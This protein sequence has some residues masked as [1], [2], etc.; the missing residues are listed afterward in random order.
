M[1]QTSPP[2]KPAVTPSERPRNTIAF[3]DGLSFKQAR[4]ALAVALLLSLFVAGMQITSNFLDTRRDIDAGIRAIMESN[5][6][7]ASHITLNIDTVLAAELARGML[8]YP[9]IT[10]VKL[11][12][13]FGDIIGRASDVG[14]TQAQSPLLIWLF[15]PPKAVVV[16]LYNPYTNKIDI[17]ELGQLIV[18]VDSS[19]TGQAFLH[20]AII[21]LIGV[22]LVTLLLASILMAQFYSQVTKPLTD[23]A[24]ALE[25]INPR[26]SDN[27]PI[28][29][30]RRHNRDEI[31]RLIESYNQQLQSAQD[32]LNKR[33]SAEFELKFY[34]NELENQV[35]VRTAEAMAAKQ[36]FQ[37]ILDNSPIAIACLDGNACIQQVN[38]AFIELFHYNSTEL[39]DHTTRLLYHNNEDYDAIMETAPLLLQM[40]QNY[41]VSVTMRHKNG[42]SIDI[43]LAARAV[44]PECMEDGFIFSF[45]DISERVKM[46]GAL[47]KAKEDAEAA[48]QA[49]SNFLANMSHEIRTPMNAILGMTWLALRTELDAQQRNYLSRVRTSADALLV[50]I[51]DILDFSKIEA[52]KLDIE[53]IPFE[54]EDVLQHLSSLTGIRAEEKGLEVIFET[55]PNIPRQLRGDPLRLGQILINLAFNAIKF[56]SEGEIIVA[57]KMVNE[58]QDS[59]TGR[60]MVELE[61]SVSDTGIGI[62]EQQQKQLFEAF[63][64]ADTSITRRFGGTGLGL[65]ISRRLAQLMHGRLSVESHLGQG[66]KFAFSAEFE[67]LTGDTFSNIASFELIRGM[68]ALVVDDNDSSRDIL[69]QMLACWSIDSL[70]AA[71]AEEGLALCQQQDFDLILMDWQLPGMN[72]LNACE[73]IIEQHREDDEKPPLILMITAY[74]RS[75]LSEKAK[76]IGVPGVLTKPITPSQLADT[77]AAAAHLE[78][79]IYIDTQ[80]DTRS[81]NDS[82][83]NLA[84][85][86]VLLVEDN[87]INQLL[88]RE[89]LERAQIEVHV[90]SDG[91]AGVY[92][93]QQ[94]QFDLVLMDL[95]MPIMDGFTATAKIR[96]D[97]SIKHTPIIAMTAHAMTGQRETC[98]QAGMNDYLAKPVEPRLLYSCLERWALKH[99]RQPALNSQSMPTTIEPPTAEPFDTKQRVYSDSN[100]LPSHLPGL[101]IQQGLHLAANNQDLY[102]NIASRFA[103]SYVDGIL[104]LMEALEAND[105]ATAQGWLHT[106]KGLSGNLGASALQAASKKLEDNCVNSS[107]EGLGSDIDLLE[108]CLNQVTSSLR[109]LDSTKK[110]IKTPAHAQQALSLSE[111][112]EVLESILQSLQSGDSQAASQLETLTLNVDQNSQLKLRSIKSL[113]DD[114][115]FPQALNALKELLANIEKLT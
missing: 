111:H 86:K 69:V 59:D 19:S 90:C 95:Q 63:A 72:G 26:S 83:P 37:S 71:T 81:Q 5:T 93:L 104:P 58:R 87:D 57:C 4:Q 114:F 61:I 65:T 99:N 40:G 101:N 25:S 85:L 91:R 50:I 21:T 106:I 15:G 13:S 75:E 98:L 14:H 79:S 108:N 82:I 7:A 47:L 38:P 16:D 62:S 53:D 12:D 60:Q 27:K 80:P 24:L 110:N 8:K 33:K 41:E 89:L 39:L 74:D 52:G 54:L 66:S 28:P 68:K 6:S 102:L 2:E 22:V 105:T 112:G 10:E 78:D 67:R 1:L 115:E 32:H 107:L 64:Q 31:G 92:A 45:W 23:M 103:E 43:A 29:I 46:E 44:N 9:G 109:H 35:S 17:K 73:H 42:Q 56:T 113:V 36:H 3:A 20:S 70:S 11:T 84:G 100:Q 48:T 77:I 94:Q 51:N 55:Q 97:A 18:I 34:M 88:A 30:P 76:A 96:E 49:K